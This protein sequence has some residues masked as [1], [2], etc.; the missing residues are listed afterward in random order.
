MSFVAR[1]SARLFH[2][3]APA[4]MS[5]SGGHGGGYGIWK[6]SFFLGAIPCV[7]LANVNA[8]VIADEPTPPE[9][10]PY[11]YLRIRSKKFP[12]GDGQHSLFHNAH[13]NA[14]P[15]GYEGH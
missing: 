13:M 12:W 6:K 2:T 3:T 5:G 8:F 11:A 1:S 10:V 4:R 15:D 7:I 14:L 9:F